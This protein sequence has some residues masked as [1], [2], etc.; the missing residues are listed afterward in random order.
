MAPNSV[1]ITL[2]VL[3][4]QSQWLC[5]HHRFSHQVCVIT[6][7]LDM[8][9]GLRPLHQSPELCPRHWQVGLTTLS[10]PRSVLRILSPAL[11]RHI[12]SVSQAVQPYRLSSQAVPPYRLSYL[13]CAA[14]QFETPALCRYS[15]QSH[16]IAAK[17]PQLPIN[18]HSSPAPAWR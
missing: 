2:P 18:F 9:A 14:I 12:G 17:L 3:L 6:S 5:S 16:A 7:A 4:V 15:Y 13:G 11:C 10:V 8:E 1:T